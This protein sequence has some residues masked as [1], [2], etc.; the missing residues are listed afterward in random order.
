MSSS[1]FPPIISRPLIRLPCPLS[2]VSMLWFS[3][4]SVTGICSPSSSSFCSPW[5]LNLFSPPVAPFFFVLLSADFLHRAPSLRPSAASLIH[6][7]SHRF[8]YSR[9]RV[10]FPA[11][12]LSPFLLSLSASPLVSSSPIQPSITNL[13]F[14]SGAIS[15]HCSP[16]ILRFS[17]W[18]HFFLSGQH[19]PPPPP[20]L[21]SRCYSLVPWSSPAALVRSP[22]HTSGLVSLLLPHRHPSRL[23]HSLFSFPS[24][25]PPPRYLP[26]P[27]HPSI[28]LSCFDIFLPRF[29][30]VAVFA[31]LAVFISLSLGHVIFLILPASRSFSHPPR[32]IFVYLVLNEIL[33]RWSMSSKVIARVIGD[34]WQ[35]IVIELGPAEAPLVH[36]YMA[37]HHAAC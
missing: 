23:I 10:C 22:H 21:S 9:R 15:P 24:R 8:F 13:S 3:P 31:R 34:G 16:I 26:L 29:N 12:L 35:V 7:S 18:Y 32:L 37:S 30:L 27:P 1:Y 19:L 11:T 25:L 36:I 2:A 6:P 28:T 33:I 20:A 14:S 4:S 17:T 5:F